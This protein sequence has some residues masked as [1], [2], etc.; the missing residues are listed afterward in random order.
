M[1]GESCKNISSISWRLDRKIFEIV[2][3][4][5]TPEKKNAMLRLL[6]GKSIDDWNRLEVTRFYSWPS[7]KLCDWVNVRE[8]IRWDNRKAFTCWEGE[9]NNWGPLGKAPFFASKYWVWKWNTKKS[10]FKQKAMKKQYYNWMR[11][12]IRSLQ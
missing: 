4:F 8:Y 1:F 6:T 9:R 12:E 2:Y 5:N 3:K 10:K 7:G 11:H